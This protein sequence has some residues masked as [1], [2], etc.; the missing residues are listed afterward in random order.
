MVPEKNKLF[1]NLFYFLQGVFGRCQTCSKNMEL[2]VCAF[3]C[4]PDQSRFLVAHPSFDGSY[5]ES[6]DYRIDYN[7]MEGVFKSCKEVVLPSTG[8]KAMDVSCGYWEDK[9]DPEKWY[10]FMGN[11]VDNPLVP[12]NIKYIVEN[13]TSIRFERETKTCS[14][15]YNN[16]YACSCVDCDKSCPGKFTCSQIC[17]LML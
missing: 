8:K 10:E 9:C 6:I 13:D 7:H 1:L 16:S 4:A 2:S 14:E 11:A 15:A 17:F 3:T 5:V 12:F